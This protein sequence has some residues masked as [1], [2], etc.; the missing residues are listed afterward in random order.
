M[1]S[2][3]EALLAAGAEEELWAEA[4]SSVIHVLNRSPKAGQDVTPLKAVTGRPPDVR[5]FR[6]WGSRALTLKPKQQQ[7]K[8]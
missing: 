8:L 3:R 7:R 5:E 6:V 2:V 4:L 1:E